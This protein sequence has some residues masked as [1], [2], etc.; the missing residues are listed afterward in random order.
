MLTG[1][2]LIIGGLLVAALT[3]VWVV[4]PAKSADPFYV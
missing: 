2:L 1:N 4:R 3:S